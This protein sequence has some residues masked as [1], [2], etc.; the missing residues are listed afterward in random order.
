MELVTKASYVLADSIPNNDNR[1]T[2]D[3]ECFIF[4]M[5]NDLDA[6]ENVVIAVADPAD[7]GVEVPFTVVLERVREASDVLADAIQENDNRLTLHTGIEAAFVMV[8]AI[9]NGFNVDNFVNLFST[10]V[11]TDLYEVSINACNES[12]SKI[13]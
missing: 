7:E 11:I 3:T 12:I 8:E 10:V 6:G 5:N 13:L 4:R 2:L 9:G 1:V